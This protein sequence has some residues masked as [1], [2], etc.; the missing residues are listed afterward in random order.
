MSIM[1]E[2]LRVAAG[3]TASTVKNLLFTVSGPLSTDGVVWVCSGAVWAHDKAVNVTLG[4][5]G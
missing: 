1:M 2:K 4:K 5:D 3:C